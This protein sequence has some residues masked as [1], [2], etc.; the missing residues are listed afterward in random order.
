MVAGSIPEPEGCPWLAGSCACLSWERHPEP[1]VFSLNERFRFIEA[2]QGQRFC[3]V[4]SCEALTLY[5]L[6][7]VQGGWEVFLQDVVYQLQAEAELPS[8]A[9][10]HPLR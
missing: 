2:L 5:G 9:G 3:E 10:C 8:G 7:S 4:Q 6:G 1:C